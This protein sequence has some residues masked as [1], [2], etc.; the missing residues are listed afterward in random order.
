[1]TKRRFELAEGTSN[2]FWE[3]AVDGASHTVRFGR[4]GTAGQTKTKP[5]ASEQ[6]ARA[7][8]DKLV[9]EKLA[10]GYREVATR[11]EP[12]VRTT[13][14]PPRGRPPIVLTLQGS[15]LI[16]D[17]VTQEL[18]SA[19]EAKQQLDQILR[20][21]RN[22]GYA[23]GEVEIA[24]TPEPEPPEEAEEDLDEVPEPE[25]PSVAHDEHGRCQITFELEPD[26][27]TCASLVERLQREAPRVVQILCDLASPGAPWAAALAKARLPSVKDFIFD[28]FSQTQTRQGQNSIGDLRATL[29][30]LPSLER[31]FATGD[32]VLTKGS[33]ATLRE[34]FLLGD[35]LTPKFLRALAQWKLAALERL[36]L[37]LA[38]DAGPG[39]DDAALAV[40]TRL[41]APHLRIVHVESLHDVPHV[42]REL[43]ASGRVSAWKEL[44]LSGGLDE[45]ELIEVVE[46]NVDVL[47]GLDVF[48][49]PLGNEVS[50]DGDEKLRALCACVHDSSE[51][52]DATL[53]A[54]YD[55]WRGAAGPREI[56]R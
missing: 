16:T 8:R 19:A 3:I 55:A 15:R 5:F 45:D 7:D 14:K 20:R 54:A 37:S 21:R 2:K 43:I 4:I 31:L 12:A 39:D 34:M 23:I 25:P 38:S 42:I 27:S 10:K 30:A 48:A 29:D 49:L 13:L 47:R 26:A 50:S 56:I 1:V 11:A 17:D 36:V 52:D 6:A 46:R 44:V 35:P 18:G 9:R 33:H 28:T 41:D 22:E 32:L 51:F 40:L 53:P 24:D